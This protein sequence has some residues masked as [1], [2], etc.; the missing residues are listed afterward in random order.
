MQ[1]NYATWLNGI[2][3]RKL[4]P[5]RQDAIDLSRATQRTITMFFN[6]TR[7]LVSSLIG[8]ALLSIVWLT[9]HGPLMAQAPEQNSTEAWKKVDDAINRGLPQTAIKELTPLIE[10]A[11]ASGDHDAAIKAICTKI[12]LESNIEGNQPAERI[13]RMKAAI[14]AAPEPM[15]PVMNAIL[16]NWY[17]NYFNQNR[18]QFMQRTQTEGVPGDDFTAWSLPQLLDEVTKQFELALAD[19]EKLQAAPISS[20]HDILEHSEDGAITYRPTMFDVL[21]HNAIDVYTLADTATSKPQEPFELTAKEPIFADREALLAWDLSAND[22]SSR[23][24]RAV[25][26][27]QQLIQFHFKDED[28]TALLDNDLLRLE[29]ADA[30]AVG[31]D[32]TD[33]YKAALERFRASSSQARSGCPRD[34]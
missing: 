17:W 26:L 8:A 6:R 3:L 12:V 31:D 21:A 30:V 27:Y 25:R 20:F 33:A 18:W 32:K 29:F 9:L 24:L 19:A 34:H 4:T 1:A 2:W 7:I 10:A 16:A 5:H 23:L 22:S 14:A 15:K 28:Q 13:T 11:M